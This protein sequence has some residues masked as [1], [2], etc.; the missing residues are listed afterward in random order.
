MSTEALVRQWFQEVWVQGDESAIDR[1]LH[2][3]AVV[4]GLSPESLRGPEAFKP[5]YRVMRGALSDM[6]IEIERVV[7]QGDSCA[8][9]CH[10][11]AKHT[12]DALGGQPTNQPLK[13]DGI[14]KARVKDG[15]LVEGWNVF[16]FLSM[17]QQM[18][19]LPNPV[20]PPA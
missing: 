17:Y 3:D 11:N 10:V 5:F 6:H 7:V 14:T 4:H 9:L 1:L 19:W 2:P 8:V 16:D 15:Q 18:G 12:G 13:C 20:L